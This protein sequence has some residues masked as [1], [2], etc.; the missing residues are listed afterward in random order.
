[1]FGKLTIFQLHQEQR[2]RFLSLLT[3]NTVTALLVG[4]PN[5]AKQVFYRAWGLVWD[6]IILL[7]TREIHLAFNHGIEIVGMRCHSLAGLE[8]ITGAKTAGF[9]AVYASSFLGRNS[10]VCLSLRPGPPIGPDT[11]VAPAITPAL[12]RRDQCCTVLR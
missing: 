4:H 1:M 6:E 7:R 12:L 10:L 5:T 3:S 8:E 11:T 9:L 2:T